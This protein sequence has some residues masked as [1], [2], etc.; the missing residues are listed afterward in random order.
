MPRHQMSTDFIAGGGALCVDLI[1]YPQRA[2]IGDAQRL[3]VTHRIKA[4]LDLPFISVTVN[5]IRYALPTPPS[6]A[7]P[8]Y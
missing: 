3:P 2:Q 4:Y 7:P 8:A 5:S 1:T 6:P